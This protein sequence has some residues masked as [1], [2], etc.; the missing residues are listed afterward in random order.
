MGKVGKKRKNKA[1]I[2]GEPLI[3]EFEDPLK[4]YR[5]IIN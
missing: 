2:K 4:G 5:N 1:V 3:F